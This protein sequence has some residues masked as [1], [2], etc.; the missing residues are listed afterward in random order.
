MEDDDKKI[1]EKLLHISEQNNRL[2]RR[3]R[4]EVLIARYIHVFYWLII[5][6]I[7][8]VSYNY[9]KPYLGNLTVTLQN[10]DKIQKYLPK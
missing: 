5:L 4:R 8:F 6:G 2:L 3:M 7:G 9:L 10:L 1:L